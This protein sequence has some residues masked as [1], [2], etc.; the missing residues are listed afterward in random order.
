MADALGIPA[1]SSQEGS[2]RGNGMTTIANRFA[3]CGISAGLAI[4]ICASAVLAD[5]ASLKPTV[6]PVIDATQ[7]I[8]GQAIAY[9]AGDAEITASII[10]VPPGGET[11]W[12]RH[13][14]PLFGYILEGALTVDYGEKG[15]HT[16]TVGDGLIE[17]MNWPHNGM[18]KGTVPVK[19][20][21]VYAGAKGVPDAEAVAH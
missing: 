20:L 2:G 1:G 6:T 5:D 9:P 11:G 18:N 13:A 17:A 10:T 8:L 15:T 19:I 21:A 14:V 7:T 12:H 3:I 4:T 16:Y